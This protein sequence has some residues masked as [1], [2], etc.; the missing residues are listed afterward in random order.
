MKETKRIRSGPKPAS[1]TRKTVSM[2]LSDE[3]TTML[4]HMAD[5]AGCS[6]SQIIRGVIKKEFQRFHQNCSNGSPQ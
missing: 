3:T 6:R 1:D 2:V 4:D 5:C